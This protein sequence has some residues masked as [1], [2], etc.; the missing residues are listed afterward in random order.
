MK[1]FSTVTFEEGTFGVVCI[2]FD[3]PHSM[4]V[5]AIFFDAA[6]ARDYADS[7]NSTPDDRQKSIVTSQD[8]RAQAERTADDL[9]DRQRAVLE[10]LKLKMDKNK[11]VETKAATLAGLA[12]IPL[13]S[14]HSVIGSLEKKHLIRIARPGSAR[15]SAVYEVL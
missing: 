9:S 1:T 10:A 13:G 6:R 14:L 3:R 4:E 5:I 15:A 11:L 2:D 7:L 12:K 8:R